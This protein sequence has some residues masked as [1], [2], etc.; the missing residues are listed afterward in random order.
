V[1]AGEAAGDDLTQ[2]GAKRAPVHARRAQ[3]ALVR[4]NATT[5]MIDFRRMSS[6]MIWT[7]TK[8]SARLVLMMRTTM[9]MVTKC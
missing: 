9:E 7:L 6:K 4:R 8:R 5:A 1:V 2:L 3:P